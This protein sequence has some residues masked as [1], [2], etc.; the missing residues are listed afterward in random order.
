[1]R[2]TKLFGVYIGPRSA[3]MGCLL[4]LALGAV[5]LGLMFRG[6]VGAQARAGVV[7]VS[8]LEAPVLSPTVSTVA[9]EP[10]LYEERVAGNP[11]L[12]AEP[13]GEGPWP[14]ILLLNGA[15]PQGKDLPEARSLAASLARAGYLVVLPDLPGLKSYEIRPDTAAEALE[16]AREVSERREARDDR[17]ALVGVS[18][19]AS[20]A[21][22]TAGDPSVANR[23]SVVAGVA[24]YASVETVLS[25]A[26]TGHHRRGGEMVPYEADPY[27]AYTAGSSLVAMVPDAGDRATLRAAVRGVEPGDKDPL[28]AFRSL[29]AD[30]LGS[31]AE[32]VLRLLANEDP[33]R[34]GDLYAELTPAVRGDLR[35]LS[36]LAGERLEAPVELI[37]APRDRYFP[38]S[39]SRDVARV[40][41]EHRVAVTG[42]LDHADLDVSPREIPAFLEVNGFV[43]RS[44]RAASGTSAGDGPR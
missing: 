12:V 41:P 26:T 15:V 19:G 5:V 30:G 6:Y 3:A 40:A 28:S 31:D 20:L 18:T 4:L 32:A 14:A 21:L 10:R 27:L 29:D 36:P 24:P 33:A 34:F 44:L 23:V 42:A 16:A 37:S 7:L 2:S 25:L 9:G 17:V 35:A 8:F 13:T 11:A 1:M 43:I 38:I 39:E 22:L